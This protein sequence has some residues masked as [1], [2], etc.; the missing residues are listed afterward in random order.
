[1]DRV[2]LP[3]KP[4][5]ALAVPA[6]L[7]AGLDGPLRALGLEVLPYAWQGD[8]AVFPDLQAFAGEAVP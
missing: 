7:P 2:S 8:R 1:M 6:T 3:E 5:I 4:R